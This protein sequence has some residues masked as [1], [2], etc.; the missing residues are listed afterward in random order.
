[1]KGSARAGGP[2]HADQF[3]KGCGS[4]Y[5]AEQQAFAATG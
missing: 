4:S 1:M 2:N 5:S 3:C